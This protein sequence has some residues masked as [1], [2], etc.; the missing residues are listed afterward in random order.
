MMEMQESPQTPVVM[1]QLSWFFGIATIVK[2]LLIPSY[3]STDL[4]VH[5]HWLAITHSLPLSQWYTDETSEWTLDYP[6]FFAYLERFLSMF[7]HLIDPQIV[8]LHHGLNYKANSAIYFQRMSVIVSDLFLLYGV[9]RSTLALASLKRNLIWLLVIWSPG[10]LIVDHLHFQYNGFLFGWLLLSLSFLAQGRDVMGGFLFAVLL[11]FKHLFAVAAPVYFVYLLRHYCRGGLVRGFAR[12]SVMGAIVVA[13]FAAAYGPFVYHGQIQ[14]VI[15]RMFPFGRGLCHAYW[16]P[17]FWVF[18]IM[19]DKGIAFLLRKFGFNIPAPVASFTGGLVGDASPFA[20]LPRVTPLTTFI[21]V[22][23]ALSPCLF[24]TWKDPRP[25]LIVRSV[26]YAYTCGFLFGWHVHEKASLHFS[27]PLAIVAVESLEDAKHYFLLSIVS[28]YSLFPLL[29]E[30]QE[31]PIKVLLLLLH[32]ILMWFSF[33]AQYS[34][35]LRG[36]KKGGE[37]Q[38]FEVGWVT[39][40]YLIGVVVVEIWGQFLHPYLFGDKL[41]FV[42]LMLISMYC[43]IG[44]LYSWIWQLKSILISS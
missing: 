42:P 21:M 25:R 39:K 24:R 27:I 12:L 16:A 1:A 10:L 34:G 28:C 19:L 18:Y 40:S 38:G 32:T 2:L 22:L 8:H 20:I 36:D 7:A 9:Y 41:P 3:H 6:P 17:N 13:V 33:S 43:A 29:Y 31:Y 30:A 14:Q 15:R 11:C 23:L 44:I 26:A 4:E 37:K 5:R 35:S